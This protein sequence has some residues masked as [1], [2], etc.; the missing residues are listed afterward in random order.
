MRAIGFASRIGCPLEPSMYVKK[1]VLR[2][3]AATC[4]VFLVKKI[5]SVPVAEDGVLFALRS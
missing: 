1:H 2:R 4:S 5:T 3:G